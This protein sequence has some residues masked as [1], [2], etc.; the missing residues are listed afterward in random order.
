MT[1]LG[2]ALA[3]GFALSALVSSVFAQEPDQALIDAAK[4]EGQVNLY[5]TQIINQFV[6]PVSQAFEKKYGIKVNYLRTDHTDTVLRILNEGKAGRMEADVFTLTNGISALK[7]AGLVAHW[8]PKNASALPP[9]YIDRDGYWVATNLYVLSPAFNTELIPPGTEPK[10]YEDLLNPQLKG[11]IAWNSNPT[12]SG[13]PGFIG[14]MLADMGQ[15]KGMEFLKKFADQQPVGLGV[16]ARQVLDQVIAGEYSMALNVFSHHAVISAGKGA[17]VSWIRM[18]PLLGTL[19]IAAVTKDA[20]HPN[21][22]RLLVEFLL[23]DEG[24]KLHRDADYIP[25]L[26]SVPPKDPTLQPHQGG[27]KLIVKT[28]EQLEKEMPAWVDIY[29]QL[30]R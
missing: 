24:Q 23:S 26:D 11:K 9:E 4:K 25:V 10:T 12:A 6:V 27:Y 2:L 30:F 17:P 13:A 1:K 16:A 20:P 7:D 19:S 15:E 3:T 29:N 22:A 28:P 8:I 5:A 14:L 18:S 21:A